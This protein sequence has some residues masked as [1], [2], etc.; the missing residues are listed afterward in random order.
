MSTSTSAVSFRS[1]VDASVTRMPSVGGPSMRMQSSA[2]SGTRCRVASA[3]SPSMTAA[4]YACTT[5]S[6]VD[7]SSGAGSPRENTTMSATITSPAITAR[8]TRRVRSGRAAGSSISASWRAT[9]GGWRT[10]VTNAGR[11]VTGERPGA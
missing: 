3:S 9:C 11:V 8:S 5:P 7:R 4:E 10:K 1:V 6:G 2:S